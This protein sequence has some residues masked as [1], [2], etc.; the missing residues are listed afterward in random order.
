MQKANFL[1]GMFPA[2]FAAPAGGGTPAETG[3]TLVGAGATVDTGG[4]AWANPGNITADDGT[5][6]SC[7][8]GTAAGGVTGDT[9]RGST[10]GF[11][12][13]GGATITGIELRVQL[14]FGGSASTI[15]SVNIGKDDSTLGT[16]KTPGTALTSTPTDYDFGSSSDLWGLSWTPAEINASTLQGLLVVASAGAGASVSCDAMWMNVHYTV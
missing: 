15:D 10:L 12:V 11:A 3:F 2:I 6:A 7:A 4:S 14:S 16:A 9:L 5:N 13:P 8:V 1:P